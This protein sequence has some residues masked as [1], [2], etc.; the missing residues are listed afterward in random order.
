MK[1]HLCFSAFFILAAGPVCAE[2][3][4]E[5][6]KPEAAYLHDAGYTGD[7]IHAAFRTYFREVEDFLNCW[8]EVTYRIH[9]EARSASY[10]LSSALRKY[11]SRHNHDEAVEGLSGFIASDAP[12]I[13]TGTL[14]LT[15]PDQEA[16]P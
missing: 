14:I 4:I 7:E 13:E 16:D 6:I 5:P 9:D 2:N 1:Q 3:C 12:L 15:T 10:E 11:P 8:N